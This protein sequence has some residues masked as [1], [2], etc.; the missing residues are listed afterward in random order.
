MLVHGTV[1]AWPSPRPPG[2]TLWSSGRSFHSSFPLGSGLAACPRL[3]GGDAPGGGLLG[4]PPEALPTRPRLLI[5]RLAQ[6]SHGGDGTCPRPGQDGDR[7]RARQW[8]RNKGRGQ[9][10]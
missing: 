10:T 4:G 9:G 2:P 6:A 5:L 8:V 1:P 3:H 7:V